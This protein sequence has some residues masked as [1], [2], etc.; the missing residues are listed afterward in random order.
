MSVPSAGRFS[1]LANL[2]KA[3]A[4]RA[5]APGFVLSDNPFDAT[6][7]PCTSSPQTCEAAE[8]SLRRDGY[9]A[10]PAVFEDDQVARAAQLVQTVTAAGWPAPFALVYDHIWE[11]LG[12][13]TP[14]V[15]SFL[16]AP[17]QILPDYWIWQVDGNYE[18]R[19]W[20]WHRDDKFDK[21]CFDDEDRPLILT[22]WLPFTDASLDNG[23][24]HVLPRS[25]DT[26]DREELKR[27]VVPVELR[28]LIRPL[29]AKAGSVLA[30]DMYALHCGSHFTPAARNPRI[31]LGIYMQNPEIASLDGHPITPG[32]RLPLLSRL[33]IISRMINRYASAYSFEPELLANCRRWATLYALAHNLPGETAKA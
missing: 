20:D 25:V 28:Q 15:G 4:W 9:F 17:P 23:C 3:D 21:R 18:S 14:L 22:V 12:R 8:Q 1:D 19:G 26:R 5:I 6:A 2:S 32:D 16:G 31:S 7:T 27:M 13:L 30:W 11:M 24:I 29:P 10:L 33:G